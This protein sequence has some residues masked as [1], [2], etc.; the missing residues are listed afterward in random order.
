MSAM[1]SSYLLGQRNTKL[2]L[3]LLYDADRDGDKEEVNYDGDKV[4]DMLHKKR[5][6]S[7]HPDIF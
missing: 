2:S 5:S 6:E 1:S 7:K 4:N 3:S